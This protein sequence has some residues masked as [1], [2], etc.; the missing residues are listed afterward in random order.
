MDWFALGRLLPPFMKDEAAKHL[1]GADPASRVSGFHAILVLAGRAA[2]LEAVVRPRRSVKNGMTL[3]PNLKSVA[4]QGGALFAP[5]PLRRTL[6][7]SRG[8]R[9]RRN[10]SGASNN[11]MEP[12]WPARSRCQR[13]LIDSSQAA[14]VSFP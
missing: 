7:A 2:H 11:S 12:T 6:P 4:R 5:E 13:P 10:G 14:G 9:A 3:A 1:D 8:S